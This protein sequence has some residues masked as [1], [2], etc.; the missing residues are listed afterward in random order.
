[1]DTPMYMYVN[2]VGLIIQ[3]VKSMKVKNSSLTGRYVA[4]LIH[5]ND[6]EAYGTLHLYKQQLLPLKIYTKRPKATEMHC[7]ENNYVKIDL[8]LKE[9]GGFLLY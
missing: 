9:F 2:K 8:I 4:F 3:L 6:V 5:R 1:M 7:R